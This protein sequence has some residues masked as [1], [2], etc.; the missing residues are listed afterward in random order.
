MYILLLCLVRVKSLTLMMMR[1]VNQQNVV[2]FS[3]NYAI[4]LANQLASWSATC[5]RAA[6]ELD[7][8]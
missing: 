7:I 4:Q 5:Y 8:V 3:V 6:S 2:S 1:K